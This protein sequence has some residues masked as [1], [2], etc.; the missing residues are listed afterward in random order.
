MNKYTCL[1]QILFPKLEFAIAEACI[2][3]SAA[4]L[5]RVPPIVN[6][7]AK[8]AVNSITAD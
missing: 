7:A 8:P 4:L 2:V 6:V 5:W 1:V 3:C